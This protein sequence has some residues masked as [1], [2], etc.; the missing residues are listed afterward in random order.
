MGNILDFDTEGEFVTEFGE[1][2]RYHPCPVQGDITQHAGRSGL[3]VL[4]SYADD[5]VRVSRPV[6]VSGTEGMLCLTL[7]GDLRG[8][9]SLVLGVDD[10]GCVS[11][12]CVRMD[13]AA[14][15]S[16]LWEKIVYPLDE[17]WPAVEKTP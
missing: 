4:Y 16:Q 14:P 3:F 15:H 1:Y 2:P 6:A 11:L 9:V 12:D 8:T 5:G 10:E 13:M 7:F 17:N